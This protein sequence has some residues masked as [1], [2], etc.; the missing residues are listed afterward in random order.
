MF[1]RNLSL[2]VCVCLAAMAA[3]GQTSYVFLVPGVN[4]IATQV[5]GLGDNDFSRVI[6]D[7]VNGTGPTN[8]LPGSFK[9]LATPDGRKFFSFWC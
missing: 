3:F 8:A 9:V 6:S 5:V 2:A 7:V 1:K 4:G